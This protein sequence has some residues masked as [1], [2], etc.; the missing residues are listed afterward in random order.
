MQDV[1]IRLAKP[2]DAALFPDIEQSAGQLFRKVV[3]LE[4]LAGDDTI[5]PAKHQEWM[6]D[7][8]VWVAET[9][10]KLVAFISTE[11]FDDRMHIWELDVSA[12]FQRGGIGRNLIKTS[13]DHAAKQKLKD[14][15]FTTFRDVAFNA[16]FYT[17]LGFREVTSPE[18]DEWLSAILQ[19]EVEN[20]LPKD[21]RCAMRLQ[22]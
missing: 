18:T 5:S 2:D 15:T 6:H 1:E 13:I 7:G 22:L 11:I 21:R 3:G 14:I 12:D 16:P 17:Q 8:A 4:W 9:G 20:G 10:G 19:A